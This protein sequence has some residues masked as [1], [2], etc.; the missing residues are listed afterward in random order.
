[1][2]LTKDQQNLLSQLALNHQMA[3]VDRIS[4]AKDLDK[5]TL[6]F[7]ELERLVVSDSYL[8][9]VTRIANNT[10]EETA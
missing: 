10:L 3:F 4:K 6:T 8:E 7:D 2:A 1:M 5:I 9:L